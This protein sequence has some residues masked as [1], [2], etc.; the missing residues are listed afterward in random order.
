LKSEEPTARR[1]DAIEWRPPSPPR[2]FAGV[3]D[4][5]EFSSALAGR[6]R[7]VREIGRGGMAVV[8]LADDLRHHRRVAIKFLQPELAQAVGSARF[9]REI[10]IA[11]QLVHPH[12]VP[13]Y[14]SGDLDGRLFYVMPF[15]EGETL[16]QRLDRERQ[17]PVDEALALGRQVA[18]ALE[19][20]H[21]HGVV[22]R[23]IK[24]ENILL[25]EG[26]AMV[27]DFGIARALSAAQA[28]RITGTGLVVGTPEY[29][30]P[31][32][33]LDEGADARSDQYSL[34][35]VLFEMLAGEPPY[36]GPTPYSILSKRLMDP[37]PSVRR[38]RDAVPI[39]VDRTIMR[40]LSKLPAD[41]YPT[42]GAFASALTL[43]AATPAHGSTA[44]AE[45]QRAPA[46]AVLPFR[47]LSADPENEYFADGIT[48]D[49][50]AH[51]S[52]IHALTVISRSSVMPFKQRNQS[53]RDIG[54][55]LGATALLDGSV[56]R[57]GDRVRIVAQLV[58]GASDRHLWTETYDRKLD[59]IF[60]IQTDVALHIA[61]A[62]ET[63]LSPDE[64][65]RVQRKP[66]DDL[67]AYQLFLR[68]RQW[69]S[70]Y[71]PETLNRAIECFEQAIAR[72]PGFALAYATIAMA[73]VEFAE[74][75][76]I[77]AHLAFAHATEAVEQALRLDPELGLAHVTS[78]YVKMTREFD[79]AGAEREFR[80]ALELSPS[81]A[82]AYDLFGRMCAGIGR[83]DEALVLHN[84][85]QELDPLAHANDVTTTLIRAGRYEEAA[86][87]ASAAVELD[88][89]NART[90][91]TLGWAE[92]FSGRQPEGLANLQRAVTLNP[93]NNLWLSQLGE[94]YGMAGRE[95]EARAILREL[96][97]KS[98]TS[99]VSPYHIAYVHTG[100]GEVDRALDLLERAVADRTGPTYGIKGSFLFIPLRGHPRFEALLRTMNLA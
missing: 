23:D 86:K 21:T 12:V 70:R 58:D 92:F 8:Y 72:D 22:H 78:G 2:I 96:Q 18:S 97:E 82:D 19:Y 45:P 89:G 39:A 6:Y 98:A 24:P 79:W 31:E 59:D 68:G 9:L 28:P 81:D 80:R 95:E 7:L 50:I 65:T 62:L 99:F 10:E 15:I 64:R 36:A 76:V 48:E 13:L 54:A 63:T 17:L 83:F 11:A 4:T 93:K 66:T 71:T 85:A 30:S 75:G 25:F 67:E 3:V 90:R 26:E 84:R 51:L 57:A 87:R 56:R 46:I 74:N 88:Q 14:D 20:A 49:V 60:A 37:V 47:N 73:Y 94:M 16:R 55:T 32:Q 100:L 61:S 33:A 38:L 69:F 27:A 1:A 40:A 29:M 77:S 43:A 35:C 53:M 34:A 91:A 41:R 52:K 42:V 5:P 44:F